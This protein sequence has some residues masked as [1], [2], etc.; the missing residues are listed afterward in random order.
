[1]PL[2]G[3]RALIVAVLIIITVVLCVIGHRVGDRERHRHRVSASLRVQRVVSE[4]AE[5]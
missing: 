4:L 3:R 2:D 5:K 1:M